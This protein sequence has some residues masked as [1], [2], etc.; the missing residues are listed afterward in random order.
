MATKEKKLLDISSEMMSSMGE[1]L[2]WK[3]AGFKSKTDLM[4]EVSELSSEKKLELL[5]KVFEEDIAKKHLE[6]KMTFVQ[7]L[8][9]RTFVTPDEVKRSLIEEGYTEENGW[10]FP[11]YGIVMYNYYEVFPNELRVYGRTWSHTW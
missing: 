6:N 5:L 7:R 4:K 2:A 10:R 1:D 8:G 11:D 3:K 9:G